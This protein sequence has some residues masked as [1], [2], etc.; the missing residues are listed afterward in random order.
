[1]GIFGEWAEW[2]NGKISVSSYTDVDIIND[3][4]YLVNP[5]YLE[6]IS[7]Y[8]MEHAIDDRALK[9]LPQIRINTIDGSISSY[10]SIL[11]SPKWLSIIKQE[12]KLAYI[13]CNI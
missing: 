12:K 11:K 1:M 10:C 3:Q 7:C 4:Y 9:S 8:T 2:S 5:I 6:C 13:L